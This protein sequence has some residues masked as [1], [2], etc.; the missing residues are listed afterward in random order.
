MMVT[1]IR[2]V[3]EG[4]YGI[5]ERSSVR[6]QTYVATYASSVKGAMHLCSFVMKLFKTVCM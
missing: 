6:V 3:L 2:L 5:E 4:C 1:A